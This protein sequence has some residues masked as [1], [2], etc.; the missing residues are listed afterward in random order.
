MACL[1]AFFVNSVYAK[2]D[3]YGQWVE[4]KNTN[5][6][7]QTLN[8]SQDA[9]G[10]V[11]G[12]SNYYESW[13]WYSYTNQANNNAVTVTS[14]NFG[15]FETDYGTNVAVAGGYA[16]RAAN[17]NVVTIQEGTF[18]GGDIYGGYIVDNKAFDGKGSATGNEVSLS[19]VNGTIELLVG[20]YANSD[21]KGQVASGPMKPVVTMFLSVVEPQMAGYW[22]VMFH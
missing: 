4:T 3:I 6:T 16:N 8:V 11:G 1:S 14:G 21:S 2:A 10:V 19:N 15:Y 13:P 17:E 22:L 12:Y 9:N 7:G 18:S 5:V 20:G